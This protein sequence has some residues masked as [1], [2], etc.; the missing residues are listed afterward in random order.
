[1]R[2]G[3]CA[4]KEGETYWHV[5]TTHVGHG[6]TWTEAGVA[7]GPGDPIKIFT[8]DNDEGEYNW[9]GTTDQYTYTSYRIHV[10]G[11]WN[12]NGY[13]YRIYIND[14]WKRNGH[15]A[16]QLNGVDQANEIW[17]DDKWTPDTVRAIHKDSYLYTKLDSTTPWDEDVETEWWHAPDPCPA[18][19]ETTMGEISWIY[20]T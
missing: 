19:N 12:P 8:Y 2:P 5:I 15:L 7:R 16:Y 13:K 9:Y 10:T 20:K 1:M 4:V 18:K 14:Q 11:Q 6:S 3:S 17:Y